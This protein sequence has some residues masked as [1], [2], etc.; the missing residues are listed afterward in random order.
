[1]VAK[2]KEQVKG[3][4]PFGKKGASGFEDSS[5]SFLREVSGSEVNAVLSL[6]ESDMAGLDAR[7]ADE[8]QKAYGLNEIQHE[9]APSWFIQLLTSFIFP[10]NEIGRA[11]V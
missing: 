3:K 2:I 4:I 10:F 7:Q 9:K 11:H 1:M 6:L 5:A 8:K